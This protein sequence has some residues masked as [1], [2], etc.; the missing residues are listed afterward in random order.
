MVRMDRRTAKSRHAG[1]RGSGVEVGVTARSGA[2][3]DISADVEIDSCIDRGVTSDD[4]GE[5]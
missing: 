2:A 4:S 5:R 3:S 1:I